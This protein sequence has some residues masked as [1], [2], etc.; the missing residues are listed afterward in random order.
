MIKQNLSLLNDKPNVF[1]FPQATIDAFSVDDSDKDMYLSSIKIFMPRM[2]N[3]FTY[4]YVKFHV[5]TKFKFI[6]VIRLTKYPLPA[7][8][9]SKTKRVIINISALQKRS[10][11]NI[12]LRDLYTI[13]AYS[14]VCLVLSLSGGKLSPKY[15]TIV[16]QYMGFVFL[17]L[18][19]K[20]YGIT[21][22][23]VDKIP[24]FRFIVFAYIYR[25]FFGL[26]Q[27][28]AI[29]QA[30]HL[31]K[32]NPARSEV[33]VSKYDLTDFD[34]FLQLLSDSEV[35]PGLNQYRFLEQ[36]IR[37]FGTMNLP[38]FEDFMRFSSIMVGASITGNSY[39]SAAFQ[40]FNPGYYSKVTEIVAS[41]VN[42]AM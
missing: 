31:S 9:N 38:F 18:F 32:Y 5:D 24:Q 33:D 19:A 40:M 3:H 34:Q 23:Y 39:F 21:G 35:T 26:D 27:K 29:K 25:S 7:V 37:S 2:K 30:S 4:P 36:M 42:K 17:K 20:K 10:I 13:L 1:S 6:N 11:S 41:T 15:M 8:Y 14:H 16:C 28:S 12:D 22:S